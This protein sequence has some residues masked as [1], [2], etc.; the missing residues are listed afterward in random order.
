MSQLLDLIRSRTSVRSY[1]GRRLS[2]E[3]ESRLLEYAR[4]V[5]NPWG[6]PVTF[7]L[8]DAKEHGLKSPVLTG[9]TLYL[10]GVV[11]KVPHGEVAFGYSFEKLVLFAQELGIGTVWI[12]G[13]MN[14]D[15]FEAAVGLRKDERMI[16]VTP[17]GY[18]AKKR[19]LR[20]S[21]MR[22]AVKADSRKPWEELFFCGDSQ[23]PLT[24]AGL[25]DLT[26]NDPRSAAVSEALEMVRL[27]PSAVNKQPWRV[28]VR[29]AAYY[30]YEKKDRG[31][32]SEAT[33]D[34]QKTDL[35]IAI[36]HFTAGLEEKEIPY[37][38]SAADPGIAAENDLEYIATVKA[39]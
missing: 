31:Y 5:K 11:K 8:L 14:R 21:M 38:V 26:G 39:E 13:T 25:R 20:E 12:G 2:A 9:E 6:I 35:G 3:E 29:D 1:D 15:A 7:H 28:V 33:G 27:A 4:A 23:T 22:K 24:E 34:L 32:V 37:E 10:A 19:S 30:F 36:C 17:V 18:P 16:C